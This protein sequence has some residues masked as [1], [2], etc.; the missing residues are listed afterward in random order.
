MSRRRPRRPWRRAGRRI[1]PRPR[2]A[3]R[4]AAH[5]RHLGLKQ[6]RHQ[7]RQ[8]RRPQQ[9]C[10]AGTECRSACTG[11]PSTRTGTEMRAGRK[12][13]S[14]RPR[15][16][17]K[18]AHPGA[19]EVA[20]IRSRSCSSSR[21]APAAAA[22]RSMPLA[23]EAERGSIALDEAGVELRRRGIRLARQSARQ[24]RDIASADRR[25]CVRSSAPASRSSACFA[26][27]RRARSAW[28]SSDR[29]TAVISLP[30]STPVSTRMPSPS[31]ISSAT[32]R[33]VDGRKPRS[34]SSA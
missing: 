30:V 10:T 32:S 33:P 7:G 6:R 4:C 8:P 31:A 1:A 11:S 34:G 15:P 9:R 5:R 3:G 22:A 26:R 23:S 19:I 20:A 14:H 24:E 2:S 27:R 28:R 25:R 12:A 17:A 29:R 18:P 13:G 16:R 21:A